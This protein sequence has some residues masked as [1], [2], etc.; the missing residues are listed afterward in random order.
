MTSEDYHQTQEK[1]SLGAASPSFAGR[2]EAQFRALLSELLEKSKERISKEKLLEL[3]EEKKRNVGGGYL[4]DQGALFLVGADL[5]VTLS[6]PDQNPVHR[7]SEI[8]PLQRNIT[9]LG[10]L[11]ACSP[12]KKYTRK[13]DG[14]QSILSRL[15]LFDQHVTL[16]ATVWGSKTNELLTIPELHPGSLL[17]ISKAYVTSGIDNS[18]VLN[19][20]DNSKV[21]VLS[22]EGDESIRIKSLEEQII[23][24]DEHFEDGRRIIIRGGFMREGDQRQY[25]RKDGSHGRLFAFGLVKPEDPSKK[26]RIVIWDNDNPSFESLEDGE[27]VT[28]ANLRAKKV[29][30]SGNHSLELHGDD[31]TYVVE[32]WQE[33]QDWFKRLIE[34]SLR[35]LNNSSG[36]QTNLPHTA[37]SSS[38]LHVLPF[39]TRILSISAAEEDNATDTLAYALLVDYRKRKISGTFRDKAREEL[40]QNFSVDDVVLCKPNSFDEIALKAQ[41]SIGGS[42]VKVRPK[43]EDIQSSAALITKISNLESG[44]IVSV[45]SMALSE[46]L[47]REISTKEGMVRRTEL[48]VGDETGEIKVLGWRT[49]GK[50]LEGI[51]IGTRIFLR[52][53]EVQSYASKKFLVLKNFSRVEISS[54]G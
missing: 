4:T 3:L 10:R 32:K 46:P 29:G 27:I 7:L 13:S 22:E 40:I 33:T 6:Q 24:P 16:A 23:F 18:P 53:V 15:L 28:V 50:R 38:G 45:E 34:T 49:L 39:I 37:S 14:R 8:K 21:E 44:S 19:I 5:G 12:P 11:L 42:L 52:C 36:G 26:V 17:K 2:T 1:S 47:S 35:T 54:K 30:F 41:F 9:V 20:D 31:S 51:R 48:V 25:L 43:R